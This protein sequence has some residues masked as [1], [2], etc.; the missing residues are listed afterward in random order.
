MLLGEATILGMN[1]VLSEQTALAPPPFKNSHCATLFRGKFD[2]INSCGSLHV[3]ELTRL[4]MRYFL[5]QAACA[6]ADYVVVK[7]SL[8]NTVCIAVLTA[9]QGFR[10]DH[11][12]CCLLLITHL[13]VDS[14]NI[15]CLCLDTIAASRGSVHGPRSNSDR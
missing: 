8:P 13:A 12:F 9:P 1:V 2:S 4:T 11:C 3:Q 14:G 6:I 15:H 10:F 7:D 5:L